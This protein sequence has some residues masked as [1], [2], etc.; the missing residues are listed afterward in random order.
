MVTTYL[1]LSCLQV[2][3]IFGASFIAQIIGILAAQKYLT[4]GVVELTRIR[5]HTS[6]RI[7]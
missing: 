7:F 1:V 3:Q 5:D 2:L 4:C 6:L